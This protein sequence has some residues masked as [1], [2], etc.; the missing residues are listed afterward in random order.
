M[1]KDHTTAGKQKTGSRL[2]S[3]D[4]VLVGSIL[5]VSMVFSWLG[6]SQKGPTMDEP[7]HILSGYT[8][9][10]KQDYRMQPENGALPQHVAAL[11]LFL[12]SD[13]PEVDET[14]A[15][16]IHSSKWYLSEEWWLEKENNRGE[17]IDLPRLSMLLFN[18][19]GM[20]LVFLLSTNLWGRSGGYLS[21]MLAAF[22]PNFLGHMP[23]ATSDFM[24]AW[25]VVLAIVTYARLGAQ[26]SLVNVFLAGATVAAALLS[27]HSAI[28]I[29]PVAV[30]LVIVRM[31]QKEKIWIQL[32]FFR[33]DA[34][35][36][37]SRLAWM[38]T[39]SLLACLI[40]VIFI[41]AMHTFRY[42]AANPDAGEFNQFLL[43][44]DDLREKGGMRSEVIAV[45]AETRLLPEAWLY[46]LEFILDQANRTNFL[47]GEF[48]HAE[49]FLLYFPY[50]FLYKTFPPA[51]LL[52][53]TGWLAFAY[54][55]L[56]NARTL[57]LHLIGLLALALCYGVTLIN[58]TMNIGYR[59]AFPILLISCIIA[60]CLLSRSVCRTRAL[61]IIYLLLAASLIP[62]GW[63]N[64]DRYIGYM[65]ILGGG[66]ERGYQH[67]RES[68]LDW[69][70]DIPLAIERIQRE[71]RLFPEKPVYFSSF[72]PLTPSRTGAPETRHLPSFWNNRQSH[73]VPELGPGLYVISATLF[74]PGYAD[75]HEG[76]EHQFRQQR[77]KAMP[78][79]ERLAKKDALGESEALE[80][81]SWEAFEFLKGY[82]Q[83]RFVRLCRFL[84]MR[85]PDEVLN[86]TIL[87][88]DIKAEELEGLVW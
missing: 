65:N 72:S 58:S 26:I 53:I 10:T 43:H 25:T 85:G 68:S 87:V 36:P 19:F 73:L 59:H 80:Y 44:W 78:V 71:G 4:G 34:S 77:A 66:E 45:A 22:S 37:I 64:R 79:Y 52:H 28:L 38:A 60:G 42:E 56:R 2:S 51:I 18:Q 49:G 15:N 54:I 21:L 33:G 11:P 82:E 46:G 70:Q 84:E 81:I 67:L 61:S 35:R 41:Y 31:F 86:G 17:L 8:Y 14:S 23:L 7:I 74:F 13:I 9:W 3:R 76:M 30:L 16:W 32:P 88:Y 5:L 57:P 47:N 83:S 55:L 69:A 12:R 50:C 27:K 29:G 40:S 20:I 75:W 62:L 6:V 63:A 48:R 39:G 1:A 24:G